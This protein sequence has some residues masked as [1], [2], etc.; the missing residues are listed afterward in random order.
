MPT[1]R[2]ARRP[3]LSQV[4]NKAATTTTLTSS[5]N[6]SVVGQAVTFTATVS[7]TDPVPGP[8]TGT[9]TFKDGTTTLGTGTL[10]ASG[11]ATFTTSTLA[12]GRHSIK[13]TY[14]GDA[15]FKTS[16]SAVLTQTVNRALVVSGGPA[17]GVQDPAPLTQPMLAPIVAEAIARWQE[18]GA[19]PRASWP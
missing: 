15:S 18:A 12:A 9:V 17:S 7:I 6:P 16:T 3:R 1:S 19:A 4:V 13:A 11:V 14:N 10:D 5:L 2:P 8:P